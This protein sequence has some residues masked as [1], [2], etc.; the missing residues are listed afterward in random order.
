MTA[1]ALC[2][3]GFRFIIENMET[4]GSRLNRDEYMRNGATELAHT[5][6]IYAYSLVERDVDLTAEHV[7]NWIDTGFLTFEEAEAVVMRYE[8][9]RELAKNTEYGERLATKGDDFYH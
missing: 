8:E 5:A 2:L 3:G 1:L 6:D 4:N 9:L 7:R